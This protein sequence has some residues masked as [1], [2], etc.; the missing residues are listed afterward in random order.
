MRYILVPE[1]NWT[2][3]D[4]I[5]F[6]VEQSVQEWEII[7][8][9]STIGTWNQELYMHKYIQQKVKRKVSE[10]LSEA[11]LR[12]TERGESE[13]LRR[14]GGEMTFVHSCLCYVD[15]FRHSKQHLVASLPMPLA[16]F[17][18]RVRLTLFAAELAL[19]GG[20]VL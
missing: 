3:R 16:T 9:M 15:T 1:E 12:Y 20:G 8:D 18:V 11:R 6:Y 17:T 19:G 14:R 13:T 7:V 2:A 5:P 10:T 4:M